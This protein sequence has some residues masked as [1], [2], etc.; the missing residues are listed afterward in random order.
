MSAKARSLARKS[1]MRK[2]WSG[3]TNPGRPRDP[4]AGEPPVEGVLDSV[5]APAEGRE[6]P[7]AAGG[8]GVG[9]RMA[10]GA[11]PAGQGLVD[12]RER[13]GEAALRAPRHGAAVVARERRGEAGD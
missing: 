6:P 8:A 9:G 7:P 12:P 13:E 5:G 3:V 2:S 10:S 4:G 1:A 11:L